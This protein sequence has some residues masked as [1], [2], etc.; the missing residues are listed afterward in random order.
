MKN[1]IMTTGVL[2]GVV[3]LAHLLRV[4]EERQLATE[5]WYVIMTLITAG[6][7]VWAWLLLR[8]SA[9]P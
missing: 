7:S 2:F 4:V 3:T 6:L 1:Y 5:P 8:P 9:R